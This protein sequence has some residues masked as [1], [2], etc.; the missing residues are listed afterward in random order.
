MHGQCTA[1]GVSV[2]TRNCDIRIHTLII[3]S[4]SDDSNFRILCLCCTKNLSG[5]SEFHGCVWVLFFCGVFV[6]V[7]WLL[8]FAIFKKICFVSDFIH[9]FK[10]ARARTRTHIHL[11]PC[12]HHNI[13][14]VKI[15]LVNIITAIIK[16]IMESYNKQQQQQQNNNKFNQISSNRNKSIQ[17]NAALNSLHN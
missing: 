1:Y 4:V 5:C 3:T 11:S 14:I 2:V 9:L 17:L 13:P 12:N 8:I 16:K 6:G 15:T 7:F 10:R